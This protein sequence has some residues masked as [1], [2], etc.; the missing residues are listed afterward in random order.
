ME[1]YKCEFCGKILKNK[2]TLK[3]HKMRTKSCIEIQK[4]R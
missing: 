2:Y 4:K 3:A 1:T